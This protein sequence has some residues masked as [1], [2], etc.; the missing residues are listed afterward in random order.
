MLDGTLEKADSLRPLERSS[1]FVALRDKTSSIV[2]TNRIETW[3]KL[4]NGKDRVLLSSL[5]KE[6]K[7]KSRSEGGKKTT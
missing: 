4:S 7:M 2:L 6:C 1:S 5:L 3:I